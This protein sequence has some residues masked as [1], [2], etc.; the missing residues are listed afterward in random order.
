MQ[1]M[2]DLIAV[3]VVSDPAT[4]KLYVRNVHA[5]RDHRDDLHLHDD[6]LFQFLPGHA[7]FDET[8]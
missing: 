8:S 6:F 1:S 3:A 4:L 5:E 7:M 2:V